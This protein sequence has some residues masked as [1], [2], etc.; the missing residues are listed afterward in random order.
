MRRIDTYLKPR[1]FL[2][3]LVAVIGSVLLTVGQ[4]QAQ[5]LLIADEAV[6]PTRLP[7]PIIMPPPTPPTISYRIKALSVNAR[8]IDQI[9]QVQVAQSFVNTGSRQMQV[10][11]V[12]PLPYDGAIDSLTL[13]VDGK[14][15]PAQ[16]MSKERAREIYEGF[17][18]RNEDPALLE[19]MG[20]GMFQTSVF[21]VPPGAERKVMIT[22]KQLL[23]KDHNLTDLLFPLGTAKYTSAAVEK[24]EIKASIE[25][26]TPIKSVYSPTHGVDIERPDEHHAIVKYTAANEI[27]SGDFRL[28]YDVTDQRL[29]ASVISYR[30]QTG[31]DGYFLL[32]SSPEVDWTADE[33]TGKNVVCVFDRSGSMSGRKF[34]Q[35]Q[36]ALKFVMNN[37]NDGD[38]FNLVAYDTEVESFKPELQPYGEETRKAGIGFVD[39]L[40]AG[41]GTN[42]DGALQA[43]FRMLPDDAR[44]NY[45][46][47]MTDGRP[48]IGETNEGKIVNVVQQ[49]NTTHARLIS[50]GVGFDVNSRLLDRL[51]RAG[52][53]ASEYVR[54]NEDI[55]SHVARLYNKISS[56]A[57]T[58]VDVNFEFDEMAAED[59]SPVTRVYP[60]QIHD[61]FQGEQLVVV[62]RYRKAGVAKIRITGKVSGTEQKFDFP[63]E[64]VETS[65]DEK[66]A[67]VEKLWA[68]RRI[69]QIVDELD[70]HGRN[71]ELIKELVQLS[72]QH[73][74]LTPYTSFLADDTG[75]ADLAQA[76]AGRGVATEKAADALRALDDADGRSG[77]LQRR[78]KKQWQES[79]QIAADAP[80]GGAPDQ[81]GAKIYS[82]EEDREVSVGNVRNVGNRSIYRRGQLWIA[83]NCADLDPEKDKEKIKAIKRYS[84]AYFALVRGNSKSQNEMLVRQRPG[85]E[86][87][88]RLRG[89]AYRLYD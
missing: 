82:V 14:E 35:A 84:E 42:I 86:L 25:S 46:L 27:P 70:L 69:G 18:R 39:T 49:H 53:G 63:A 52:F 85:E 8:V 28:F 55:E 24:I 87:L 76:Q 23:R 45:I 31:E 56:P 38:Y 36:R 20:T 29:G 65:K 88:I 7:R 40:Y 58:N 74:I 80:V 51:S 44:P 30:P 1:N 13:L 34:E 78:A 89:Q 43:A 19:W 26:K 41:G 57:M 79:Q 47:F 2:L 3:V 21:P 64:L 17:M 77:F 22:Y 9:A 50:F 10:Q 48:T 60:R 72:T 4:V 67:F 62:G 16:L 59:G 15:Y 5:G 68:M 6:G 61:L 32:L 54:P 83:G 75:R 33:R 37:L 12:F 73:G 81:A 11:F 66:Y 71:D